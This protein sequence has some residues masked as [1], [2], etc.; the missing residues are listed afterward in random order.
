MMDKIKLRLAQK[1]FEERHPGL[2]KKRDRERYMKRKGNVTKEERDIIKKEIATTKKYIKKIWGRETII[3]KISYQE[4]KKLGGELGINVFNVKCFKDGL[5][6]R[7]KKFK[8]YIRVCKYC[9][10]NY[11]IR[12][13]RKVHPRSLGVCLIC[14][15]K[16]HYEICEA[17]EIKNKIK[18]ERLIL[19]ALEK[20]GRMTISEIASEL[21]C[22]AYPVR[23]IFYELK[24]EGKIKTIKTTSAKIITTP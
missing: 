9:K 5:S 16:N 11:G 18:W 13:R 15:K 24:K 2:I 6:D 21:R 14:R 12:I 23:K 22:S 3:R 1:R 20:N 7:R 10:K 8:D 4:L 17:R 19:D